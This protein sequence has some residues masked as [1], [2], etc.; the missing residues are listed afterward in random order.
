MGLLNTPLL[1]VLQSVVDWGDRGAV[2]ALNQFSRTI[3]GAIGV[4][5]VGVLLVSR[6][7]AGA[8]ARGLDPSRFSDPLQVSTQTAE[9]RSLVVQGVQA[10]DLVFIALAVVA[11]GV[12]AMILLKRREVHF[13]T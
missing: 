12:A 3:G 7:R 4:A 10:I 6:I 8:V 13:R 5:R 9:G 1:I 11:L 2:T